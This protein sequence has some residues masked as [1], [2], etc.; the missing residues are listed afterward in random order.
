M[1]SRDDPLLGRELG[2]RGRRAGA[3]GRPRQPAADAFANRP[4]L[5]QF[6]VLRSRFGYSQPIEIKETGV[7]LGRRS[8]LLLL[9][10]IYYATKATTTTTT[11]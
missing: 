4:R 9:L 3:A 8:L 10:F 1:A 2:A 5:P 7:S 11:V 6:H